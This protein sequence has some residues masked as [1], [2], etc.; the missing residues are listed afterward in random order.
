MASCTGSSALAGTTAYSAGSSYF[1]YKAGKSAG[2]N[3]PVS[4]QTGGSLLA[5]HVVSA[6]DAFLAVAS[7][8]IDSSSGARVDKWT[9]N[10]AKQM[11]HE[12]TGY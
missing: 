5:T 9:I 11:S 1:F 10:N 6:A 3:G 8:Y 7:G 4:D 12:Q 2:S